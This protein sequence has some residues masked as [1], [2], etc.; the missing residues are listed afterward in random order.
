MIE[1]PKGIVLPACKTT[2]DDVTN[3]SSFSVSSSNSLQQSAKAEL[4]TIIMNK[5]K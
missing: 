2:S 3:T 5:K 1:E 4:E